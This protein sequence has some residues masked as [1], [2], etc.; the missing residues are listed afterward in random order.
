MC[1]CVQLA[2]F[3]SLAV[4]SEFFTFSAIAFLAADALAKFVSALCTAAA[5]VALVASVRCIAVSRAA[6][7]LDAAFSAQPALA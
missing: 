3:A 2:A 6:Q 7:L 5:F 4:C 1:A